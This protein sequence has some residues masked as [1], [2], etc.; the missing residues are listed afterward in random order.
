[1][2]KGYLAAIVTPFKNGNID[3][4]ALEKYMN[5]FYRSGISGIVVAGSTGE[6]VLLSLQEKIKLVR[7]ISSINAG[8]INLIGGVIDASTDNCVRFIKETEKYVDHFLCICP[9]YVKPSQQQIYEHYKQLSAATTRGIIL[10]NNPSR[11]GASIAFDTFQR[12]CEL[13]NVVALKEC[14]GDL[15]R[16]TLWRSAVG[17]SF[18]FLTGLDDVAC[19]ALAMGASGVISVSAN[20]IPDLCAKM[21]MA[22]KENN[23]EEFFI[24]RDVMAPLHEL[25]FTEPSPAPVK[26]ALSRLG[27]LSSELRAPLSPIGAE[28]Q[29][30]IDNL[31]DKLGLS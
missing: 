2:F 12:M 5:H 28:L 7:A 11:V 14:A 3:F 23:L 10:Y 24:L 17:E 6:S 8:K 18:D 19:G 9:F 1:M 4:S 29:N 21:Y 26:Y 22:F 20:V 15:S 16:F 31:M 27:I 30:K 25:L 13:K